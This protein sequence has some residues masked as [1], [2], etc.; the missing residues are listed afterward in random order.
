[1]LILACVLPSDTTC[2]LK[3]RGVCV[4]RCVNSKGRFRGWAGCR[5][6]KKPSTTR[7]PPAPPKPQ[8]KTF[9]YDTDSS[10]NVKFEI[11]HS[12]DK[13][14]SI[15]VWFNENCCPAEFLQHCR[16]I[17]SPSYTYSKETTKS[18]TWERTTGRTIETGASFSVGIPDLG[19]GGS[20]HVTVSKSST[21]SYGREETATEAFSVTIPGSETAPGARK[22]CKATTNRY[23]I[24]VPFTAEWSDGS[25]TKGFFKGQQYSRAQMRCGSSFPEHLSP[26][27]RNGCEEM[28]SNFQ[29][30]D[31]EDDG[32]VNFQ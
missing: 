18:R 1:M 27:D 32:A 13:S 8:I 25:V 17:Q 5:N 30:P 3:L 29:M 19:I 10:G 15:H 6:K 23:T 24:K 9:K 2:R 28:K 20:S 14:I 7:R 26:T 12:Q 22:T 21:H 31:Q 16:P 4:D 11:D